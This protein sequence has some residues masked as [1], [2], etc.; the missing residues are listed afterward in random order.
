LHLNKH[1]NKLEEKHSLRFSKQCV[2]IKIF[3][4]C[5][6][7][8]QSTDA[9]GA[10]SASDDDENE[11]Y[12]AQEEGGSIASQEDTSFILNIPMSSNQRRLSNDATG[13]SSEGEEGETQQVSCDAIKTDSFITT[14]FFDAY[15]SWLL[16]KTKKTTRKTD[17]NPQWMS[18]IVAYH[19]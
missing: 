14:F 1:E 16:H 6:F 5:F 4:F 17:N 7:F 12:D 3:L 9:T 2:L 19:R 15:R 10:T 8:C 13:S 11:F 18:P